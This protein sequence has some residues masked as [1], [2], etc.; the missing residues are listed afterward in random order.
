MGFFGKMVCYSGSVIDCKPE[1]RNGEVFAVTETVRRPNVC[2]QF[3]YVHTLELWQPY[4][5]FV[6][7]EVTGL[8]CNVIPVRVMR[9]GYRSVQLLDKNFKPVGSACLLVWVKIA[10]LSK[11][12]T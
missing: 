11:P 10:E 5:S 2:F 8:G 3:S 7:L 9:S 6:M 1:N 12:T 4:F